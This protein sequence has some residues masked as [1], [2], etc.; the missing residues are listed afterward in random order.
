MKKIKLLLL[1]LFI[2][3]SCSGCRAE[4]NINI[5]K[6]NIEEVINVTDYQTATRTKQDILNHYNMWY[7]S[8]VNYLTNDEFVEIKDFRQKVEGIEYHNKTFSQVGEEYK[9]TYKY[10]YPVDKYYDSYI[11]AS[12]YN[13]TNIHKRIDSLV[14]KTG[15]ENFL[16][17]Y[18]Y[19]E[20][21]KINITI[22]PKVY[23]LNYTNAESQKN[24]TYTWTLDR[25]NCNNGEIILTLDTIDNND[26]GNSTNNPESSSSGKPSSPSNRNNAE[27]G[28]ALYI[29]LAVLV[30][31]ILLGYKW[32]TTLKGKN[33][34]YEDD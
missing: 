13:E 7:P 10:T 34:K 8:Y 22:D 33:N 15:K 26:L 6:D 3:L 23:K 25:N 16:C 31:L 5:T 11:L 14:L 20:E 28:Y 12:T 17:G 18:D 9:Y 1:S 19:F 2:I 30:L 32:F 27:S 29:V 24:N 21:V 4:Y